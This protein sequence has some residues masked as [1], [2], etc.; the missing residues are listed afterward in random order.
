MGQFGEPWCWSGTLTLCTLG[1]GSLY[2]TLINA[3]G[4]VGLGTILEWAPLV[5]RLLP[6]STAC[7]S[8]WNVIMLKG[9]PRGP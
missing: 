6:K 9:L 5:E 7:P 4:R 1:L 3:E 8:I 2:I